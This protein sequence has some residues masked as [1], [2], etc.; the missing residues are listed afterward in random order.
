[1]KIPWNNLCCNYYESPRDLTDS[2][3]SRNSPV[4]YM[5]FAC[6]TFIQLDNCQWCHLF[7]MD[8]S[9]LSVVRWW[10]WP[11]FNLAVISFK[12]CGEYICH[13]Y[14]FLTIH[15]FQLILS[16]FYMILM[17]LNVRYSAANV[18]YW[19]I[20]IYVCINHNFLYLTLEILWKN[21]LHF[22]KWYDM[23][24]YF[25]EVVVAGYLWAI[26]VDRSRI[27]TI[28]LYYWVSTLDIYHGPWYHIL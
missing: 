2:R 15:Y 7:Q 5:R 21:N 3:Q 9:K 11:W 23:Q 6:R 17:L 4:Y 19:F 27:E 16:L 25:C 22:D 26:S 8:L 28:Y 20:S 12:G 14:C 10:K 18:A 1:M 24:T 13:S